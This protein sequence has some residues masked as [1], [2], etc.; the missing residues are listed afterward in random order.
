[1]DFSL[2]EQ[3]EMLRKGAREFFANELPKT[4]VKELAADPKG[5]SV[6]LWK[7]MADLGWMGLAL[8]EEYGGSAASF[9]DLSI[10][11]EEMGRACMPGPFFSTVVLGG[12]TIAEIGSEAQKKKILPKLAKGD[13]IVTLAMAEPHAISVPDSFEVEAHETGDCFVMSGTK[14]FVPDLLE[15]DHIVVAA[16]TKGGVTLFL[17]SA[18]SHGVKCKS[19]DHMSGERQGQV[20]FKETKVSKA[21]VL[22]ERNR[23]KEYLER[24]MTRAAAG[25]CS[26]M[27]GGA[28]QVMEMTVAYAKDR[29]AF[30]RPI[31]AYQAIQHHCANMLN[32][33]DGCR[34]MTRRAAWMVSE[35]LPCAMEVSLAKAWTHQ[36]YRRITTLGHGIHG[37]IAFQHDHDMHLYFK[38]ARVG[39]VAFGDT[40]YHED[41]IARE[42]GL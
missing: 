40:A 5:Y 32:D 38:Q 28:E 18:K 10:L 39:E 17:V 26:E 25:K 13:L 31:G 30:G 22:G 4:K 33:L 24:I 34:C 41:V 35:G 20:T 11:L 15:A 29:V 12:M 37:A 9:L 8:P 21:D 2:S 6:D 7:K 23:G 36:A 16:K 42:L 1:M 19:L 14:L 3:Q 27:L